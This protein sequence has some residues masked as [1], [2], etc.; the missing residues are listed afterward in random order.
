MNVLEKIECFF[1]ER[2][3]NKNKKL[4]N[5]EIL[6]VADHPRLY[7]LALSKGVEMTIFLPPSIRISGLN[8]VT[9]EGNFRVYGTENIFLDSKENLHINSPYTKNKEFVVS[10]DLREANYR[11]ML[12]NFYLVKETRLKNELDG[13]DFKKKIRDCINAHN[14]AVNQANEVQ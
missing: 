11:T 2:K 6:F 14:H 7:Y 8:Q 13:K 3:L 1:L 12:S 10:Q 4:T 9:I 5:R